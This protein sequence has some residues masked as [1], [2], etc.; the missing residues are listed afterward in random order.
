M[1]NKKQTKKKGNNQI[2][3]KKKKKKKRRKN[4]LEVEGMSTFKTMMKSFL[5][6]IPPR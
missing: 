3:K 4:N 2:K 1:K 6:I 5:R